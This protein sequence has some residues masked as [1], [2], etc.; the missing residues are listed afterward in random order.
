MVGEWNQLTHGGKTTAE[1]VTGPDHEDEHDGGPHQDGLQ[2]GRPLQRARHP[3]P[4]GG[5]GA[6][7]VLLLGLARFTPAPRP[8]GVA[9]HL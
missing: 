4:R 9:A 3:P 8:Q 7:A 6:G 1:E 5:Q 2:G